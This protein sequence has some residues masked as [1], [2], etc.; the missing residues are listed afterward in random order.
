LNTVTH[1]GKDI[2]VTLSTPVMQKLRELSNSISPSETMAVEEVSELPE[3]LTE[4]T[5]KIKED[6]QEIEDTK[7]LLTGTVVHPSIELIEDPDAIPTNQTE[8]V[9]PIRVKT[10]SFESISDNLLVHL[11]ETRRSGHEFRFEFT[12]LVLDAAPY[13]LNI[14]ETMKL[15]F[16][17]SEITI[18]IYPDSDDHFIFHILTNTDRLSALKDSLEDLSVRIGGETHLKENHISLVGPIEKRQ[19]VIRS[20]LWLSV[21]EY[22]T[23]VEKK[24]LELTPQFDIPKEGSILIVPPKRDFVR[25][26]IPSKFKHYVEEAIIRTTTEQDEICTLGKAQEEILSQILDPLKQGDGVVFVA[27]NFN[28]EMEEIALFLLIISEICGIGFSRW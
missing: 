3:D 22:L 24:M 13:E 6:R 14:P 19:M 4:L 10:R 9:P 5:L 27:S 25:E 2:I 16:N 12:P 20:L 26:K 18:R 1:P 21:V 11:E 17:P 23:Q 7:E 28:A 8:V 15:Q